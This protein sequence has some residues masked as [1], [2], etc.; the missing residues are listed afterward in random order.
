MA[1]A[2]SQCV[3][4]LLALDHLGIPVPECRAVGVGP[5]L[6]DTATCGTTPPRRLSY[7]AEEH[8]Q[9]HVKGKLAYLSEPS[10]DGDLHYL[11]KRKKTIQQLRRAMRVIYVGVSDQTK[12]FFCRSRLHLTILLQ[13]S[14]NMPQQ[15]SAA[16]LVLAP[17]AHNL[18]RATA[19]GPSARGL[20]DSY[21]RRTRSS[22]LLI[23]A[24]LTRSRCSHLQRESVNGTSLFSPANSVLKEEKQL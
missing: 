23:S 21:G 17:P 24:G 13:R 7:T 14:A 20:C 10:G 12:Q 11:P 3:H 15:L 8:V 16:R 6:A 18:E 5:E 9:M 2:G 1:S 19:D 4:A 22:W